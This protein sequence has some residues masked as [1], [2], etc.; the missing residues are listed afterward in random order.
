M[1]IPIYFRSI[2]TFVIFAFMLNAAVAAAGTITLGGF[3]FDASAFPT[4][5]AL[6]SGGPASFSFP[7]TGTVNSD[8]LAATDSDLTSYMFGTPVDFTV[9]FGNG[10]LQNLAGGDFVIFELGGVDDLSVKLNGITNSYTTVY[11]GFSAASTLLNAI[12]IDLSDFGVAANGLVSVLE[13]SN[14]SAH[15]QSASIDAIG[16]LNVASSTTPSAVPEPATFVCLAGGLAL[17]V[18]FRRRLAGSR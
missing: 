11:T 12:A 9:T 8:L 14:A 15:T 17:L 7:T 6:V 4:S 10:A 18:L 3:T 16:G 13:I 2:I 5:A 1:K